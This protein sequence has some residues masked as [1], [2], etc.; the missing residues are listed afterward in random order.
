MS[1]NLVC[2]TKSDLARGVE[3]LIDAF[4]DDPL[5]LY[6]IPEG[7]DR[8]RRLSEY[9]QF[10]LRFAIIY[11]EVYS[12]SPELEGIAAWFP[13]GRSDMT[14]SRVMR[15][16]G[17]RLMRHLGRETITKMSSI[18]SLTANVRK[19]HLP[20]PHWHLFPIA[21]H[22]MHQGKGYAS[23]LMRPMLDRIQGEGLPCFLET[24]NEKLVS[25]YEH[26]GFEVIFK[27]TI[28]EVELSNWGMVRLPNP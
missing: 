3:V 18:G 9:F 25:L 11:G 21:V 15:A 7:E 5:N 16:G 23:T 2:L 17:L 4:W 28:P 14:N 19:Q 22:P 20:E 13:P 12:T 8:Y 1:G 24:L 10:R 6:F 26:F 27:E